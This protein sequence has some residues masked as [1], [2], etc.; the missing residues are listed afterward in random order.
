MNVKSRRSS[1]SAEVIDSNA[2]KPEDQWLSPATVA[3]MFDLDVKWLAAAREGVKRIDGPPYIKLGKGKTAPIRYNLASLRDWIGSFQQQVSRSKP[4][5]YQSITAFLADAAPDDLWLFVF[6]PD[7]PTPIEFF[8][9]LNAGMLGGKQLPLK[10][11]PRS[12][13]GDYR[14]T[15]T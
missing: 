12:A 1:L 11:L 15:L 7:H 5:P 13:V 3:E 6:P 8:E 9:A 10:W 4:V 14:P 2:I